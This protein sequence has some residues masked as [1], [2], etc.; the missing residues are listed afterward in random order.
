MQSLS[1]KHAILVIETA[2][3]KV[4]WKKGKGEERRK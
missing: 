1:K 3:L 2:I 4:E